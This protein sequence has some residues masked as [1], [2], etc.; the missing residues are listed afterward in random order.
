MKIL[1]T[2]IGYECPILK[3]EERKVE[4]DSGVVETHYVV[5]RQPNVAVVALTNDR[6]FV[7]NKELRG[8]NQK[9]VIELPGG[10]M[11]DYNPTL[12]ELMAQAKKELLEETGY[13]AQDFEFLNLYQNESNWR[14][15]KYYQYIAWNLE[16][17]DQSLEAGECIKV[18]ELSIDDVLNLLDHDGIGFQDEKVATR[19]AI[20]KFREKGLL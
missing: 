12:E 13:K 15:R 4:L 5:V 14:E 11:K 17:F 3:V 10:K 19:L 1:E 7:L 20:E 9:E 16:K 18:L 2:K 6:K 8:K